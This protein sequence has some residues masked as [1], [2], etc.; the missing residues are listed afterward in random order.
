MSAT[1][2]YPFILAAGVMQAI[3]V[4]M[5]GQL[6]K[7]LSNPWL[8]SLVSFGLIVAVLL[9]LCAVMPRPLPTAEGVRD[10]PWWAPLGGIVGAV[11]VFAGLLFVDKLGAGPTNGLIITANLVASLAVDHFGWLGTEAHAINVWRALGGLL[12]IGGV[13]LIAMF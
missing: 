10:M 12:M 4:P 8:A 6:Y 3:G 2:I 11:A 1:Y 13:T 7:S 9:V 5:N